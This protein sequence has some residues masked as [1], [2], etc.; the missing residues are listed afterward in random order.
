M[1]SSARAGGTVRWKA[2]ELIDP[3]K[4][5]GPTK[6]SDIYAFGCVCYEVIALRWLSDDNLLTLSLDIYRQGPVS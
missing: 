2:P 6:E 5:N 4:D 3:E 1:D